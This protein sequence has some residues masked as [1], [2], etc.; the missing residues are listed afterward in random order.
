MGLG[1]VYAWSR[2]TYLLNDRRDLTSVGEDARSTSWV[3]GAT[4][5]NIHLHDSILGTR[6]VTLDF[7][8]LYPGSL[9]IFSSSIDDPYMPSTRTLPPPTTVPSTPFFSFN[10][11][12]LLLLA[13]VHCLLFSKLPTTKRFHPTCHLSNN[14]ND[15]DLTG[16]SEQRYRERERYAT[17]TTHTTHEIEEESW[18]AN[19]CSV[20]WAVFS[21]SFS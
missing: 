8:G 4:L 14:D 17:Y 10:I 5:F 3:A 20:K 13:V 9:R 12:V 21:C 16:T 18:P 19:V 6:Y 7:R 15:N 2:E 11:L 1:I